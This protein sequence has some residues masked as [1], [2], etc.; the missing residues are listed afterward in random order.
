MNAPS[1]N[2]TKAKVRFANEI[3]PYRVGLTY[4]DTNFGL[5]DVDWSVP[6]PVVRLQIRDEQGGPVLQQRVTLSQLRP[7]IERPAAP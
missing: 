7:V 3:N 1:G 6:D 2:F 4:F 5:I